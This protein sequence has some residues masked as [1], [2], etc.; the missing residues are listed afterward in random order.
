MNDLQSED[1][2]GRPI[3]IALDTV[4]QFTLISVF[5]KKI[6]AIT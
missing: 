6:N 2:S 3:A 5:Q 4:S 1:L